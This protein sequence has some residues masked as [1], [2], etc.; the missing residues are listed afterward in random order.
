VNKL[1]AQVNELLDGSS[2]FSRFSGVISSR[3]PNET[4]VWSVGVLT[5]CQPHSSS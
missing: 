5:A 3:K 1:V 2:V 4:E